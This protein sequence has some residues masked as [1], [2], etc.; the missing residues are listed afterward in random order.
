[1]VSSQNTGTNRFECPK[2]GQHGA[3][4]LAFSAAPTKRTRARKFL[5]WQVGDIPSLP[6]VQSLCLGTR[7]VLNV[8]LG[9]LD[10]FPRRP[11]VTLAQLT[12]KME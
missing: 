6:C 1:M 10:A 9:P 11:L 2:I 4:L 3:A 5:V 8:R 12:L 7:S